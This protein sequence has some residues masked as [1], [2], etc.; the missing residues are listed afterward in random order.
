MLDLRPEDA[1]HKS[2]LNRLLIEIIDQPVL[3]HA[4][5]F[6]GGSCAAMLGYLD[7]FSVDLDF[8][9]VKD[10]SETILW[11]AFH[12]VF[13]YLDL[14]VMGEFDKVLFFQ[15]RYPND[16]GKRNT[17][18]LS[19]NS[20]EIHSNEYRVQYLPEIDRLVNSQTI[21]TMFA[22]KLVAV[23]DRYKLHRTVARRDIY[24]I[25]Y[26]FMH[27]YT[28]HAAVIKERTGKDPQDYLEEL[29][30][31]IR[32]HITQTVINEDLNTLLPPA[33]FQPIRKVLLPETLSF[34]ASERTRLANE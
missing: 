31:F 21:D 32:N 7:R 33:R 13:D 6:K 14:K 10:A 22:N 18:K 8:D 23:T 3:A 11:D 15:L 28:Y 17:M 26:F 27:G 24:D 19:V 30:D 1:L 16:P 25:H 34:L 20:I 9:L 12:K 4:L 2:Y 5:A 29:I